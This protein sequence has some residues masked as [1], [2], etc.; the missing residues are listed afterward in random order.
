MFYCFNKGSLAANDITK[1]C[2]D[3]LLCYD[4]IHVKINGLVCDE[5]G[6]KEI[7]LHKVVDESI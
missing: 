6:S 5:G 7:F 3:V 4:A 1:Q 2:I